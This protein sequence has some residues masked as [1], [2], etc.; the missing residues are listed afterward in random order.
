MTT[1]GEQPR[2]V[3]LDESLERAMVAAPDQRD[4]PLV[5]LEAE[6]RRTSCQRG[7]P[8]S[9]L[10]SRCFQSWVP[11]LSDTVASEK[12]RT[13]ERRPNARGGTR[14]HNAPKGSAF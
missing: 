6:Q 1:E 5:A 9:V 7:K 13:R 14:T 3:A 11:A 4:E 10:K 8:R 2:L 12:L